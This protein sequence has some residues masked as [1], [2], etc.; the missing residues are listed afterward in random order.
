[1]SE[2]MDRLVFTYPQLSLPIQSGQSELIPS[3][4]V[5]ALTSSSTARAKAT[6]LSKSAATAI[7]S[8]CGKPPPA[9]LK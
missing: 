3:V 8:P 2:V 5:A 1:M 7:P 9:V 6:M 4:A